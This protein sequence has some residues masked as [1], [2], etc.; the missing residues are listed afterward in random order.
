MQRLH[1]LQL[2]QMQCRPVFTKERHG[3]DLQHRLRSRVLHRRART[4]LHA[5]QREQLLK[6]LE[7]FA[8]RSVHRRILPQF[9]LKAV[10]QGLLPTEIL[11]GLSIECLHALPVIVQAMRQQRPLHG[12]LREFHTYSR[13]VPAQ[14]DELHVLGNK[15]VQSDAWIL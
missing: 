11:P 15:P 10:H 3:H 5:V 9:H 2:H 4:E 7:H 6:V 12:L 13:G 14:A 8:L 1:H